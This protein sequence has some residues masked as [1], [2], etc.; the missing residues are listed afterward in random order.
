MYSCVRVCVCC[1]CVCKREADMKTVI[2]WRMSFG[3]NI[4]FIPRAEHEKT[5]DRSDYCLYN[6][7]CTMD[8]SLKQ[9]ENWNKVFVLDVIWRDL[10]IFMDVF[11]SFGFSFYF[12]RE[13]CKLVFFVSWSSQLD[14]NRVF[15]E[16]SL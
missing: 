5:W 7:T 16:H 1:V 4:K 14:L 11:I 8:E 3:I 9:W 10:H 13:H 15:V 2:L 12:R 6:I